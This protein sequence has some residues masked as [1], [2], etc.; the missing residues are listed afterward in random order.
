MPRAVIITRVARRSPPAARR[1]R[2]VRSS[3]LR[4]WTSAILLSLAV[5]TLG[6][7]GINAL[8]PTVPTA[9]AGAAAPPALD[10]A[11]AG[12]DPVSRDFARSPLRTAGPVLP[13]PTPEPPPR[14]VRPVAGLNQA[15]MDHAVAIVG[16]SQDMKL[17]ERAALVAMVTAFAGEPPA[18]PGQLDGAGVAEAAT[19]R[20]GT[21]LRLGRHL[22]ARPSQ[23]WA[24]SPNSWT[25]RR[26][27]AGS[28]SG[29]CACRTGRR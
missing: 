23:G 9:A 22:P 6:V 13:A 20:R 25:P 19:R 24:R 29:W 1:G 17:P 8:T 2:H 4:P 5:L 27:P 21:Q 3:A 28:T 15:M 14:K 16:V 11:R 26:P 18:Q 10:R 7:L 12:G